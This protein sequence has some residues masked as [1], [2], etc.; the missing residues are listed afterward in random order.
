MPATALVFGIG[1]GVA[2]LVGFHG[3]APAPSP[4]PRTVA[5]LPFRNTGSDQT[6]DYL[7]LALPD[8]IATIL[9]DMRSASVRVTQTSKY[10]QADLDLQK[11]GREL[12][13]GTIVSGNFLRASDQLQI[14]LEAFGVESN[15]SMWREVFNVPAPDM[16]AMQAEV[17]AKVRA[18]LGPLSGSA[19]PAMDTAAPPKNEE[20]ITCTSAAP[21]CP[22]NYPS[23]NRGSNC[24][25]DRSSSTLP[26]HRCC[27]LW[28]ADIVRIPLREWRSD[29][30]GTLH[31]NVGAGAGARS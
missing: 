14:T 4:R 3:K 28:P 31:R 10:T 9:G 2:L 17:A 12:G 30:D 7:R 16:I 26:T 20:A 1:V 11:A 24:W 13:V 21:R 6:V 29:D 5:V 8:E 15:R 19:S 27:G 18:G 25:S 23:I 22:A